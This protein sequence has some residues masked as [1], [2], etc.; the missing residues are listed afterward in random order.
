[1]KIYGRQ[2]TSILDLASKLENV[3]I[4]V[5]WGGDVV[6][7]DAL[8][9]G[10]YL[11]NGFEQLSAFETNSVKC[12]L[13]TLQRNIAEQWASEGKTIFGRKLNHTQG[14]DIRISSAPRQRGHRHWLNSDYYVLYVPALAEWRFQIFKG[15][16]ILRAKKELPSGTD[17][18]YMIRSRRNG[19]RFRYDVAPKDALREAAKKAV[20][21]VG[22]DFGAVDVLETENGPVVLEVNSRP[23]LRDESTLNAYANAIRRYVN[24]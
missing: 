10:C 12:P 14:R 4:G 8:N 23:A 18:Q 24:G 16:S 17:T 11:L 21:A 5:R 20:N 9:G 22:Y 1:M 19:Y 6:G 15:K 2:T 7:D 13:F 3:N